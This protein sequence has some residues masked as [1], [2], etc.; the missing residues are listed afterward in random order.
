MSK[1]TIIR[2]E[3]HPHRI[4]L[5]DRH[6]HHGRTGEIFLLIGLI[7]ILTDWRDWPFRFIRDA[8]LY[9]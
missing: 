2:L 6:L 4:Y 8:T 3:K 9:E 1:R 7:L 5:F